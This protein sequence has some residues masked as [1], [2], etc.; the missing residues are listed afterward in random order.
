MDLYVNMKGNQIG[1]LNI[2][3][4]PVFGFPVRK[5]SISEQ[6]LTW[7]HTQVQ[8]DSKREF[9]VIIEGV[10]GRGY[11]GDI[12]IDDIS[13]TSGCKRLAPS[14]VRLRNGRGFKDGRVEIYHQEEWGPVCREGWNKADSIVACR[15]LGFKKAIT[16]GDEGLPISGPFSGLHNVTCRGNETS[17]KNCSISAWSN[18]TSCASNVSATI[19]CSGIVPV[20]PLKTHFRCPADSDGIKKC[21]SHAQRCDFSEDCW[22]GSDELNCDD[23]TRCDFNDIG[24][25]G[26][27]QA[28]ND[29]MDWTRNK[30]GTPS[31]YTGPSADHNGNSSAYYLYMEVSN[32]HGSEKARILVTPRFQGDNN[33][34]CKVR[35]YYHMKGSGTGSLRLIL[36]DRYSWHTIWSKTFHQG[37]PWLRAEVQ[38]TNMSSSFVVL[39]E[40][41]TSGFTAHGDISIDDVSF[42][43]ECRPAPHVNV[44]CTADTFPCGSGE[45]VPLSDQCDFN[46]DCFDGSDERN[47]GL[48]TPGRCDF[49][50][51]LCDW[52]NMTDDDTFD[53]QRLSGTTPSV[54]TGPLYDHTLGLGGQGHYMYIEASSPRRRGDKARL[55]SP[56]FMWKDVVNCTLR[57]YYHMLSRWSFLSMGTLR[58]LLKN[59]ITGDELGPLWYRTGNQG[60]QWLR[61]NVPINTSWPV[62]QVIFEGVIGSSFLGDIGIDDVSFSPECYPTEAVHIYKNYDVRLADG[63]RGSF[64]GRV[65]IYRVGSWGTICNDEWDLNDAKVV[66][67][68]LGYSGVKIVNAKTYFGAGKGR[69]WLDNLACAGN[70]TNLGQCL[71]NGWGN[72]DCT[73][74]QDAGV[75]CDKDKGRTTKAIRLRSSNRSRSGQVEIYYA[76]SWEAICFDSWNIHDAFVACRQLGYTG[77]DEIISKIPEH[78]QRALKNVHCIG[79]ES[80]LADCI[81]DW[82]SG[83]CS[84]GYAGVACSATGTAEGNIRLRGGS[85]EKEGRVEVFHQG[86]WGTV[87]DDGWTT[88]NA[89]VVCNELGFTSVRKF[90][91]SF[92]PGVGR[93]WLDRV[94]CNGK[95]TALVECQHRGWDITSCS[96]QEDVGVICSDDAYVGCYKD[97]NDHA[98]TLEFKSP[99]MTPVKCVRRCQ[100]EGF[101]YAGLEW[102][103]E[104]YCGSNYDRYGTSTS[105]DLPCF[106]DVTKACGGVWALSVYNTD[107]AIIPT[108][109]PGR[110]AVTQSCTRERRFVF[111]TLVAPL[112]SAFYAGDHRSGWIS[113]PEFPNNYPNDVVCIWVI[114]LPAGTRVKVSF[115]HFHTEHHYDFV[116]IRDGEKDYSE[117]YLSPSGGFTG[118]GSYTVNVT[119]SNVM[120]IKFFS[121]VSVRRK[122]FNLTYE[123]VGAPTPI[124]SATESVNTHIL[125][126]D[127]PKIQRAEGGCN[128]IPHAVN[129]T[130]GYLDWLHNTGFVRSPRHPYGYPNDLVCRWNIRVAPGFLIKVTVQQADLSHAAQSGGL[131]DTLLVSDGV[132]SETSYENKVPWEFLSTRNLVQVLFTSDS[133]N[134]GRGFYLRYERVTVT[135]MSALSTHAS[136]FSSRQ[137]TVP[138]FTTRKVNIN[139]AR[140]GDKG[141]AIN[142]GVVAGIVVPLL[143]III[144]VVAVAVFFHL[145]KKKRG[146][147]GVRHRFVNEAYDNFEGMAMSPSDTRGEYAEPVITSGTCPPGQAI[148]GQDNVAYCSA[149]PPYSQTPD[150]NAPG[151]GMTPWGVGNQNYASLYSSP[152]AYE[153][154]ARAPGTRTTT[155][156]IGSVTSL[157][158]AA[159]DDEF[160]TPRAVTEVPLSRAVL[161]PIRGIRSLPHPEK[162]GL[163]LEDEAGP[164][165]DKPPLMVS[166]PP[167]PT[168]PPGSPPVNLALRVVS[169]L[170]S[171]EPQSNGEVPVEFL[172]PITNEI[173]KDPVTASDGYDYERQAIRRWFRTKRTSPVTNEELTDLT[174]RANN[175]LRNRIQVFMGEH[176]TV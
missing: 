35:F 137:G 25:C 29:Q 31:L 56:R 150:G 70:E 88:N 24:L 121:D 46:D 4:A 48:E 129:T 99:S 131:G 118:N 90:L 52:H 168:A 172:C 120:W 93:L 102:G 9:Q 133:V 43:P 15:E 176:S 155:T 76:G 91:Q 21:I 165:P 44:T 51:G 61:A 16:V 74:S 53:W 114:T 157:R 125:P 27:I 145:K 162:D 128:G 32:R 58:V 62:T 11:Q 7:S 36:S 158:D 115:K 123:A 106:G 112:N 92:G 86:E 42:T 60:N 26:W 18:I 95:E 107:P 160:A 49:E 153:L 33:G 85:S 159:K 75:I 80:T 57:F 45:C 100:I 126:S 38:L 127:L 22:D 10:R 151:G 173:M 101:K 30:G 171:Q 132:S 71:H 135:P 68:Q 1:E 87:C 109:I 28:T 8:F 138:D 17:I 169:P 19:T 14:Y 96:H 37:S 134:S 83:T 54:F 65:E 66:C 141:N 97:T 12:A 140:R 23:Y 146:N 163:P 34:G 139:E 152:P 170:N 84:D 104:C 89:R 142:G 94:N 116:E 111:F 79:N 13:F 67:N 130:F 119:S 143:L 147:S 149:P 47:C 39:F 108:S 98:M 110:A 64:E 156:G 117:P 82:T 3:Q 6:V 161:P 78:N 166:T 77:A 154:T 50:T 63:K 81:T 174:V 164:L 167:E 105:C 55:I 5:L 103:N 20:C 73:H 69:I 72:H 122:G 148:T 144:A 59:T 2:Y 41:E 40:G 113:S 175:D 124:P 136:T